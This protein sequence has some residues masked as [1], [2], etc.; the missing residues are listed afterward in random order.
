VRAVHQTS[1]LGHSRETS[2]SRT[3][4]ARRL[5]LAVPGLVAVLSWPAGC[6]GSNKPAEQSDAGSMVTHDTGGAVQQQPGCNVTCMTSD[7][8]PFMVDSVG[9]SVPGLCDVPA[10]ASSGL[11]RWT[12]NRDLDCP[13]PFLGCTITDA[14]GGNSCRCPASGG[15]NG[16]DAASE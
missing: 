14:A 9:D 11:C 13:P 4:I 15:V 2:S 1:K 12:C 6:S 3:A 7:T 5:A 10:G 8:C 16:S